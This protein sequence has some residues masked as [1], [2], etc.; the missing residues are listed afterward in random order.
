M[1]TLTAA[2]GLIAGSLL[3]GCL[4]TG[5]SPAE[6]AQFDAQMNAQMKGMTPAQRMDYQNQWMA[7]E[8][9][10]LEAEEQTQA[11]QNQQ[12]TVRVYNY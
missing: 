11:L 1:M 12:M 9:R 8:D 10:H 7:E 5:V 4:S 6:Q 2:L 3:T